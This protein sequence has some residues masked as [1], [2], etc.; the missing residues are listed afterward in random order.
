MK[1]SWVLYKKHIIFLIL[2]C[3]RLHW[4]ILLYTNMKLS[5]H[6]VYKFGFFP[7]TYSVQEI[8]VVLYMK[9]M[10]LDTACNYFLSSSSSA[11][12]SSSTSS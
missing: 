10:L 8:A 12:S 11:F 6:N 5:S 7:G 3:T 4:Y 1:L 9:Y 2:W